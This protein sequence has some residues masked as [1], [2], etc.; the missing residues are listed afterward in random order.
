MAGRIRDIKTVGERF[1]IRVKEFYPLAEL[2]T[3]RIGGQARFFAL[4]EEE[5]ALRKLI[6]ELLKRE[7][8]YFIIGNGSKVLFSENIF[9]GLVIKLGKGFSYIAPLKEDETS[10]EVGGATP[11]GK[12]VQYCLE[13]GL[14]G[15][16]FLFGIPGTVGGAIVNNAGAFGS[17]FSEILQRVRIVTDDGEVAEKEKEKIHFGY[18]ESQI[19]P[20]FGSFFYRKKINGVVT[21]AIIKL[22]KGEKNFIKKKIEDFTTY[23]QSTQ[24]KG[25]SFGCCFKN[26]PGSSAGRLIDMAGLK[27]FRIGGAH[28][29]KKHA[30][31]FLNDGSATFSD[32][33]QLIELVKFYVERSSGLILEEEV[34]IVY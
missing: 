24:P 25:L 28:I 13:K 26:P 21:A 31:F 19:N 10:L 34:R 3:V 6:K 15:T 9:P 18:R 22:K 8:R 17:S 1:G 2:T 23:R 4:V 29:A 7:V 27:G 5:T 16:E 30:N 33:Y 12:I 11:L 14:T 20:P 32:F